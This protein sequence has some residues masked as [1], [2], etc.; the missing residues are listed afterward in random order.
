MEINSFMNNDFTHLKDWGDYQSFNVE[1]KKMLRK[2]LMDMQNLISNQ[3]MKILKL[4]DR[5]N[6]L[7]MEKRNLSIDIHRLYKRIKG[8]MI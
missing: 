1:N 6:R 3:Q 2:L 8:E 5:I 4:E 7:E